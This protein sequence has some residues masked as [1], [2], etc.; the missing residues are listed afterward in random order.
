MKKTDMMPVADKDEIVVYQPEGAE[1]HIAV[2]V[3]NDTV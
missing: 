2:R 1:F 3:E